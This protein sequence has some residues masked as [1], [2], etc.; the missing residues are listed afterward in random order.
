MEKLS[1]INNAKL[2][3]KAIYFNNW[4]SYLPVREIRQVRVLRSNNHGKKLEIPKISNTFEHSAAIIFNSL[5]SIRDCTTYH[6]YVKNTRTVFIE[7]PKAR[8]L[9]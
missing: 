7:R 3:F 2:T 1:L 9:N 6:D 5:H 4:Q 8:L